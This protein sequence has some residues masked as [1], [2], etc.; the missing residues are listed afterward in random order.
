MGPA[1]ILLREEVGGPLIMNEKSAKF[2]H[3][4]ERE[5]KFGSF[6]AGIGAPGSAPHSSVACSCVPDS[7]EGDIACVAVSSS[8]VFMF[9]ERVCSLVQTCTTTVLFYHR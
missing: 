3:T 4:W 1:A 5:T 8:G 2:Y 7:D 6:F 9:I